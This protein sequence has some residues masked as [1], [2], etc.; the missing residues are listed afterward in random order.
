MPAS[1]VFVC[2]AGVNYVAH[3]YDPNGHLRI[4]TLTLHTTQDQTIPFSQE[5][6]YVGVV[7]G[8]NASNF[9]VQQYVNRYGHCNFKP[10]E[11]LNSFQ[12]LYLW[13]NYGITPPSGDVTVP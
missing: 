8:A 9:L 5:A 3:Y 13:V 12:G 7:A 4:P 11:I 2:P 1:G 6:H 10:E